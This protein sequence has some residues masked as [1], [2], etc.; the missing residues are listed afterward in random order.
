MV[1]INLN[2]AAQELRNTK[3]I[4]IYLK[5]LWGFIKM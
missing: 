3:K 2:F 4:S 5:K 1:Y